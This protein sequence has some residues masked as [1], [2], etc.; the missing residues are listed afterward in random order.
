LIKDVANGRVV[1][2]ATGCIGHRH[3][4]IRSRD[5]TDDARHRPDLDHAIDLLDLKGAAANKAKPITQRLWNDDPAGAVNGGFHTIKSTI[6]SA[7]AIRGQH[8]E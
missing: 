7:I 5:D 2:R 4:P 3:R 6:Q 8:V 1:K